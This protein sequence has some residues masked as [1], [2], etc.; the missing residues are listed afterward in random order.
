MQDYPTHLP[1]AA[2]IRPGTSIDRPTRRQRPPHARASA[3]DK[4][5]GAAARP[6]QRDAAGQEDGDNDEIGD[7]CD[8]CPSDPQN[9]IDNDGISGPAVADG[10]AFL[11][12]YHYARQLYVLTMLMNERPEI[13][14]NLNGS[15]EDYSDDG[16]PDET[17]YNI[18]QWAVNAVDFRDAD[19]IMTPFEFDLNPFNGWDV[20]GIIGTADDAHP[21]QALVWGCERPELLISESIVFHDRR[22]EDEIKAAEA[23]LPLP[24]PFQKK[25]EKFGRSGKTAFAPTGPSLT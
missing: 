22:T 19:A 16:V 13:D 11:A 14:F 20:D 8:S 10:D 25:K 7:V 1:C 12:R 3:R 21:D 4:T 24:T 17:Q 9:D 5:L 2:G 23:S 18:A 6:A 15:I